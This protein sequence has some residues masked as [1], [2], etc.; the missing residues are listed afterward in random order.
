V[1]LR[2]FT[3]SRALTLMGVYNCGSGAAPAAAVGRAGLEGS[4]AGLAIILSLIASSTL[5]VTVV[6]RLR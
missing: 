6:R 2:T 4:P 3:A 5:A 1:D